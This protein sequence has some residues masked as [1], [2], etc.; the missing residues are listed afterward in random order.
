MG[1]RFL[2][3]LVKVLAGDEGTGALDVGSDRHGADENRLGGGLRLVQS[4][5]EPGRRFQPL[6][7]HASAGT[8]N[9]PLQ[10]R[11]AVV[12]HGHLSL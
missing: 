8:V 12:E 7:R 9:D 4:R 3:V 5:R 1:E 11:P 2:R 10:A 6:L